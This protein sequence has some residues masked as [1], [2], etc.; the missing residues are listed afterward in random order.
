MA[1][2]SYTPSMVYR[3]RDT[4]TYSLNE[5]SPLVRL[6]LGVNTAVAVDVAKAFFTE[7]FVNQRLMLYDSDS[8]LVGNR[9]C[10][11]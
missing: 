10:K 7:Q 6:S 4:T 3:H 2:Q 11:P 5:S 9:L 8:T 1:G